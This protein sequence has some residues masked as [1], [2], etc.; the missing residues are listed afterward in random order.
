MEL[1][2]YNKPFVHIK[3]SSNIL[4][5]AISRL[6]TL[7]KQGPNRGAK[8]LNAS[9]IQHITEINTSKMHTLLEKYSVQSKSRTLL[10]KKLALQSHHGN[11]NTSNTIIISADDILQKQQY[12]H[13][14]KHD[15]KP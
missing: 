6:K 13:G 2:D 7:Y 14:L 12:I 5:D 1:A 3:G 10:V 9:E 11:K 15:V 8:K 4:V